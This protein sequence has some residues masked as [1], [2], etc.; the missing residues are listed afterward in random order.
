MSANL[1]LVRSICEA[2]ERGD[3]SSAEW[4]DPDIE[5]VMA[6]GPT[7][8][9]WRGRTEM[10]AGVRDFLS[11]WD[12]F[13]VEVD[14]YRELEGDRV[15]VLYRFHG[16]GKSSGL[17]LDDTG[18]KGADVFHLRD[19]TV[20]RIVHYWDRERASADVGLAA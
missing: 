7:P 8:G 4:A 17:E 16:R 6:D 12:G 5:Y 15:L 13:R 18:T 10:A 11:A 9:T 1:D 20:T 3:Y 14:G 2:R 19:G